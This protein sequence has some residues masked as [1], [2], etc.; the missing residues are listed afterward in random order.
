MPPCP[1]PPR[2]EIAGRACGPRLRSP[3]LQWR[4]WGW[5]VV[6]WLGVG[7]L[8]LVGPGP[9]AARA[10]ATRPNPHFHPEEIT[11]VPQTAA[12][13]GA[14]ARQGED[15]P[16]FLGPRGN[17]V[18][19][20]RG[21]LAAWPKA[22]P[23]VVW[24]HKVGEGYTAPAI[25]GDRLVFFH[26]VDDEERV[27]CLSAATGETLWQH[28]DPTSFND[29]YGYNGGPR[30]SPILSGERCYVFGAEGRLSC[31]NLTTGEPIWQR[32]TGREFKIPR[33]FFGVG[34]T[35]VLEGNLL[36]VMVGGHPESGVVA[37]DAQT[38]KTVWESVGPGD[39]PDAPRRIE[40]DRPPVKLASY[41]S[42]L[43]AEFHG[44]RHLL[45]LMRPGLISLDP[46][47]GK[48]N[49]ATWFRS[50]IHDSVN[51]ARPV[52]M[53]DR[54][55]LSSA[56]DAGSQVL[57]VA[58]DGQTLETVW[59]DPEAMETHWSTTIEHHG[60]LYGF[61]GRHEPG[62][63]LRC[64]RASD[65]Q[66]MWRTRDVNEDEE[67]DPKAGLGVT[68]PKYYGRGSALL[69]D[70]R[71]IVMGERGTLALVDLNP[72]K[73][74]EI[75]R[76]KYAELGYPCWTAPVLS[77]GRLYITG[78]KQFRGI[79]GFQDYMYHLICLDLRDPAAQP[80]P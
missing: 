74:Q 18:S 45:C 60:Y 29:P 2:C 65:G 36:L 73:F 38:G 31:L 47:T 63:N 23:P 41:S 11:P 57:R 4:V 6:V 67:P 32:E 3:A 68:E 8:S 15:W 12:G 37:L 39:F 16:V 26:R 13:S 50:P 48:K 21:L 30:C 62:S 80:G 55:F 77:R 40:R 5:S 42:P 27:E 56:Y 70:G 53:G 59:S 33:A 20:E 54:I 72:E 14:A 25:L 46:Q 22:G 1:S 75:S 71:L 10:Q 19:G 43:V 49:F 64:I 24:K 52:V 9:D 44:R 69:A 34:S 35:P 76:V 78:A 17:G 7:W 66:L 58:P 79:G 28:S 61:S 51:A